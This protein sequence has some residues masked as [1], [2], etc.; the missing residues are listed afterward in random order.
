MTTAA[1]GSGSSSA[2]ACATETDMWRPA[3]EV[4]AP[5]PVRGSAPSSSAGSSRCSSPPPSP[6]SADAAT[7]ER[8]EQLL[9]LARV[10]GSGMTSAL[11]RLEAERDVAA[12]ERDADRKQLAVARR[13]READALKIERMQVEL[14]RS[15]AIV[16]ANEQ[17][18]A[19]LRQAL[20]IAEQHGMH[21]ASEEADVPSSVGLDQAVREELATALQRRRARA[22]A[23]RRWSMRARENELMALSRRCPRTH[24]STLPC[25]AVR[26]Q[27]PPTPCFAAGLPTTRSCATLS[28]AGT[29]RPNPVRQLPTRRHRSTPHV[30]QARSFEQPTTGA[31]PQARALPCT[32]RQHGRRRCERHGMRP[33][34]E[35]SAAPGRPK[36]RV[37]VLNR[38]FS[39][40]SHLGNVAPQGARAPQTRLPCAARLAARSVFGAPGGD[41]GP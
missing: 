18:A 36:V 28:A 15:S 29:G 22:W 32:C 30:R 41:G 31:A 2:T 13:Q 5:S 7:E 3:F 24:T 27:P 34:V 8:L 37:P 16:Q 33:A 19:V 1:A 20:Q 6:G 17:R 9:H 14:H 12:A 40:P 23:L 4:F 11:S 10:S 21:G 35:G 25:H 38:H 26:Q 39:H